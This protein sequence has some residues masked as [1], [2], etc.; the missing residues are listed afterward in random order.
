[1]SVLGAP[2]RTV[3]SA[4]PLSAARCGRT[5]PDTSPSRRGRLFH[6]AA[7]SRAAGAMGVPPARAKPRA[8]GRVG[9]A[10]PR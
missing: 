6:L 3:K 9:A 10:A 5:P 7:G 4:P 2:L 1:M 8:W